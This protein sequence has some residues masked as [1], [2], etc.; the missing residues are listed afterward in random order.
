MTDAGIGRAGGAP[1]ASASASC[2]R[3]ASAT[4]CRATWPSDVDV[5]WPTS[6]P[7]WWTSSGAGRCSSSRWASS[8]AG[9]PSPSSGGSFLSRTETSN[10]SI[11]PVMAVHSLLDWL[12]HSRRGYLA[13]GWLILTLPLMMMERL[14]INRPLCHSNWLWWDDGPVNNG[15]HVQM[16]P[17]RHPWTHTHTHTCTHI[18][19]K[20]DVLIEIISMLRCFDLG[21]W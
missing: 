3:M 5:T 14:I 19:C 15:L 2:S 17:V 7:P 6:S 16:N 20:W 11:Y 1:D 9:W 12:Q 4:W 18:L 10:W 21:S 13:G 8:S